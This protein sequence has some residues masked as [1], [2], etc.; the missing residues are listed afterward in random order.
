[1]S[2]PL[3]TIGIPTYNRADVFLKESLESVLNQTYQNIEIIVSDNNSSDNT[4]EVVNSY[5]DKRIKYFKQKENLGPF[6]NMN[7]CLDKANGVYFQMLHDDDKIDPEFIEKCMKA[8]DYKTDK[9]IFIAGSREIDE[10][11]NLKYEKENRWEGLSS[12]EFILKWY[13]K[14]IHLFFC[15]ILFNTK[16]L[17]DRG[18]FKEYY[19]YFADLAAEF[20]LI[21]IGE[22]VD[23]PD[24]LASFRAHSSS[25]GKKSN[26]GQWC[27][28][29]LKL[30]NLAC[31]LAEDK[32]MKKILRSTGMATSAERMYRYATFRTG[33]HLSRAFAYL[34][35]WSKFSYRYLPPRK[36]VISW[37][38]FTR[39]ILMPR[40]SLK[41]LFKNKS[42]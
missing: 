39:F 3:V 38:P 42:S 10:D 35:V 17:R 15:S 34:T 18:G 40:S 14:K 21:C 12:E 32:K 1:M 31:E 30:L 23:V 13:E 11:G 6:K 41:L 5:G 24:V 4:E 8:A 20:E 25:M 9:A 2:R 29:S 19:R 28:D 33:D 37:V 36:Y 7:Y 22:R 16:L 26:I 27:D